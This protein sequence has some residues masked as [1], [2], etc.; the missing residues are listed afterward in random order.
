MDGLI[1]AN[2]L[3]QRLYAVY[4]PIA[5]SSVNVFAGVAIDLGY[6]FALAA[7]FLLLY[8][9][10]PGQTALAKGL[11]FALLVWFLRVAMGVAGQWMMFN[12]PMAAL[13]YTLVT[14]FGEMLVLSA[15]CSLTLRPS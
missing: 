8:P 1:N 9:S 15:L 3:A 5:K 4:R 14:G 13:A 6:G 2:P 12:V 10:L 11:S 7:I